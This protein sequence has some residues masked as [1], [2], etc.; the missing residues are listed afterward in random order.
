MPYGRQVAV[1]IG[2]N[3][4]TEDEAE[5]CIKEVKRIGR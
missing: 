5:R 3:G 1:R 4:L 2:P